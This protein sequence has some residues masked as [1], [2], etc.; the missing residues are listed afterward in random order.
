ME[1]VIPY[2]LTRLICNPIHTR[3]QHKC[4]KHQHAQYQC[5]LCR[6]NYH[7]QHYH[8]TYS[9]PI[10]CQTYCILHIV[11]H[12]YLLQTAENHNLPIKCSSQKI[13][14]SP[15]NSHHLTKLLANQIGKNRRSEFLHVEIKG[16]KEA[17]QTL[18]PLA[19]AMAINHHTTT[20]STSF[21]RF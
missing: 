7:N 12:Y 19:L 9:C 5:N 14:L 1:A 15:D 10:C 3:K 13:I 6:L 8:Y 11:E 20:L 18:L 21:P 4:T 2:Y 17:T 16:P